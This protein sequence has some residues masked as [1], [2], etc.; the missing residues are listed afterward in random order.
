M[1]ILI[2]IKEDQLLSL[3]ELSRRRKQSRAALIRAA[4]D[5]F[6]AKARHGQ[7]VEAFGLWGDRKIDGLIYQDRLRDEW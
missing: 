2:D 7:A 4:I 3:D 1:R 5:D 6:L